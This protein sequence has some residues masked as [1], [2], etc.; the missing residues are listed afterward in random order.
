[1]KKATVEHEMKLRGDNDIK[2]VQA[3]VMAKAKSDR[4]N[5]DINMEQLKLKAKENRET[6]IQSIQTA[7]S[8]F[9]A[10]FNAFVSDW[11]KVVTGAA[12]LTL[13]AGGVYTARMGTSV[14]GRYIELRLGKP[15]LVRQTSRLT[16]GQLAKHPIQTV[17]MLTRPK[18]DILKGVV[19]QVGLR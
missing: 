10:G 18:E 7:G 16:A 12:G 6:I 1:M 11:D 2:K 4:E 17:K 14:I 9:G 19:L 3:E 5:H 15:S 13:L 8:V